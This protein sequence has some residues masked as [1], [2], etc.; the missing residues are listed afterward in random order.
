MS[1]NHFNTQETLQN[2][3]TGKKH[4]FCSKVPLKLI[5][6]QFCCRVL[7]CKKQQLNLAWAAVIIPYG[8]LG[9]RQILLWSAIG[10]PI[11]SAIGFLI[12]STGKYYKVLYEWMTTAKNHSLASNLTVILAVLVFGIVF[13]WALSRMCY[14][15]IIII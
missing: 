13:Q 7:K 14:Y 8:R 9:R 3:L 11:W 6:E 10:L 12:I 15:L 2:T 1:S 5:C 4:G